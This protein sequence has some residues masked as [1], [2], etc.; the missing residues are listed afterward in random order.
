MILKRYI[1]VYP[2]RLIPL[3]SAVIG[4]LAGT[5]SAATNWYEISASTTV[6]GITDTWG[7]TT[8]PDVVG[9]RVLGGTVGFSSGNT[10]SG[11]TELKG[12]THQI[13]ANTPFGTGS[14][15]LQGGVMVSGD[16]T[17]GNPVMID[18]NYRFG[19]SAGSSWDNAITFSQPMVLNGNY[20]LTH[21]GNGGGQSGRSVI[22]GGG[23]GESGAGRDLTLTYGTYNNGAF[24]LS[25]GSTYTGATVIHGTS[26]ILTGTLTSTPEIIVNKGGTLYFRRTSASTYAPLGPTTDVFL[27]GGT[28]R[29]DAY[30]GTVG[31]LWES[32]AA[33][34]S[35][36]T[37]DYGHSQVYAGG[38]RPGT[39]LSITNLVRH[40]G[41][42]A[43]FYRLGNAS[44]N[45]WD[46][47][48]WGRI[49]VGGQTNGFMGGWAIARRNDYYYS[50]VHYDSGYD[51][52]WY[53]NS[54][55][56]LAGALPMESREVRPGQVEGASASDHVKT[57]STQTMLTGDTSIKSLTVT[58]AYNNDLG[59]YTLDIV[60]GGLLS[61][62]GD[63]V[64][65]NGTLT[66]GGDE[67]FL[68]NMGGSMNVDANIVG[69]M[70]VVTAGS[71]RWNGNNSFSGELY[72][73]SG[74]LTL[75]AA[76][77]FN[78]RANVAPGAVLDIEYENALSSTLGLQLWYDGEDYGACNMDQDA[79][80]GW[81]T[82]NDVFLARGHYT[83]ANLPGYV[84]GTGT[85]TVRK[86]GRARGTVVIFR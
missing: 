28:I 57:T 29:A 68:F 12:G 23:V 13:L 37:L 46:P 49:Y 71:M 53:S 62:D 77:S 81:A 85:L 70:D 83:S 42:T 66:A 22:L 61:A 36:V 47:Y 40:A 21:L 73:N 41:S 84:T 69:S 64:M 58:G 55:A 32:R 82:T 8:S 56:V 7:G 4:L 18:G 60:S 14:V 10:Y 79:W 78:G 59:G 54:T 65:T 5:A 43:F 1:L 31:G 20:V 16:Y 24:Y 50:G 52:G 86:T 76:N 51:F 19:Y 9:V 34:G 38:G 2:G 26:L 80:V 39:T 15:S 45:A 6:T 3:L 17:V 27:R 35:V 30:K 74:T 33:I 44:G 63:Y 67:L 75:T 25:G 11:G 48:G 72:V